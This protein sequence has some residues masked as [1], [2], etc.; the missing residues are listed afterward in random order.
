[1]SAMSQLAI[2]TSTN[3]RIGEATRC[4]G[5]RCFL[6][7]GGGNRDLGK[8]QP[9][10]DRFPAP[11]PDPSSPEM[12]ISAGFLCGSWRGSIFEARHRV[13]RLLDENPFVFSTLIL[14]QAYP[15][16]AR[17]RALLETGLYRLPEACPWTIEQILDEDFLP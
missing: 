5:G 17:E 11:E 10:P 12:E 7:N 6:Q 3:G 16:V 1:M 9:P 14:P 15:P 4:G 13:R 8:E 2:L